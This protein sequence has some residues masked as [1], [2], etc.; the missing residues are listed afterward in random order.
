MSASS[1]EIEAM[2][3]AGNAPDVPTPGQLPA[4]FRY[5]VSGLD[6]GG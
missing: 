5:I 1:A 3:I 2:L 6:A 4:I